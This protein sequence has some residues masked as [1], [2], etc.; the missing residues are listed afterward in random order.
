MKP[1]KVIAVFGSYYPK[2]GEAA[3]REAEELG[4]LIG[5]SG[6]VLINGGYSGTMEA[7][8]TGCREA[9]GHTIGVT[10]ER[11]SPVANT[12]IVETIHTADLYERIRVLL[13]RSDACIA[14]AGS[15]GT[16]AE[17]GVAWELICK[18]WIPARPLLFLGEFWRLLVELVMPDAHCK[19]ACKGI[20]RI[21][22]TPQ[23][24]VDFLARF[25]NSN[26]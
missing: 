16:L 10:V 15:T 13:D 12:H 6:W 8:A 4:R 19:A 25:W 21:V 24:A 20:A 22:A 14:L 9:G 3:Y 23:A 17:I 2:P 26:R 5:S 1:A 7:S 18:G 11:Y